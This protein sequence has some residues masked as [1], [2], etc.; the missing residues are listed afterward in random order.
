MYEINSESIRLSKVP[1]EEHQFLDDVGGGACLRR[2]FREGVNK[3]SIQPH[4]VIL[5]PTSDGTDIFSEQ[6]KKA[7]VHAH[8][9][10]AII[11]SLSIDRR[12]KPSWMWPVTTN[13]PGPTTDLESFYHLFLQ[14]MESLE[15]GFNCWNGH[16]QKTVWTRVILAGH[17]GDTVEQCAAHGHVG[18]TGACSCPWCTHLSYRNGRHYS[19]AF[20][21]PHTHPH[22]PD[23][24]LFPTQPNISTSRPPPIHLELRTPHSTL[25]ALKDLNATAGNERDDVRK[26]TGISKPSIF[27]R[28][29]T[30]FLLYPFFFALDP[31]HLDW[32]NEAKQLMGILV[33]T[34]KTAMANAPLSKE[35]VEKM[36]QAQE[37]SKRLKSS[38]VGQYVRSF[39]DKVG[40]WKCG[41]RRTFVTQDLDALI[42]GTSATPEIRR[43]IYHYITM[44][45]LSERLRLDQ[46]SP[47][48]VNPDLTH[49]PDD[50]I[51][52]ARIETIDYHTRAYITMKEALFIRRQPQFLNIAVPTTHRQM[53][54]KPD[55]QAW[56]PGKG[57][58]Q[59]AC[60]NALGLDKGGANSRLHPVANIRNNQSR[61]CISLI[62]ELTS[63]F[64]LKLPF[65]TRGRHFNHPQIPDTSMYSL[66]KEGCIPTVEEKEILVRWLEKEGK[67]LAMRGGY[68]KAGRLRLANGEVVRSLYADK[69]P[70]SMDPDKG[71]E[72]QQGKTTAGRFVRVSLSSTP[73]ELH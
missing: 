69:A 17:F 38:Q 25:S 9:I 57:H 16:L 50:G 51:F 4:D 29:A 43:L 15:K 21:A 32:A 41:E 35:D 8:I 24:H 54:R 20:H 68:A 13:G 44:V 73:I 23:I 31:M 11:L 18:A 71:D 7:K 70:A 36:T 3:H 39:R 5:V 67:T 63:P 60:E 58:A 12:Y 47:L 61:R 53:H 1:E 40:S 2:I 26:R 10:Y 27:I 46:L 64:P 22:Y 6:D 45:V 55:L 42:D 19:P 62:A 52:S 49:L 28:V 34:V 14:E 59:W 37:R 48:E 66:I 30:F 56:G 65:P 33:G 72:G